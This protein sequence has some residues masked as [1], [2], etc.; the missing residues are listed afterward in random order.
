MTSPAGNNRVTKRG[1]FSLVELLVVVA[2]MGMLAGVAAVSLR[3]LRSPA[4]ASAANEVASAMKMTRQ[5]AISAGRPMYLLFPITT[6]SLGC[7]PFRSYAIFEQLRPF[8]SATVDSAEVTN[9]TANDLFIPRTDWRTL[10]EGVVICNLSSGNY[11]TINPH[12]FRNLV[13][14][15]PSARRTQHVINL[16]DGSEWEYFE[17]FTNLAVRLPTSSTLN[18]GSVPFFGFLPTGRAIYNNSGYGQG[19]GVRLTQGFVSGNQVAVV[20]TN[21]YYYVETDIFAGRIRVRN[22]ESFR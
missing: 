1:G 10:P 8:E 20:D 3:G 15:Q 18:L 14:G 4:L 5:M 12:P 19:A 7:A 9:E 13:L 16:P 2:I 21:N 17:S 22:R 11:S 6:N